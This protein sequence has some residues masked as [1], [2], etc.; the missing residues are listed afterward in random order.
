[1][2]TLSQLLQKYKVKKGEEYNFTKF[3][4]PYGCFFVPSD[5]IDSFF[6]SYVDHLAAGKPQPALTEKQGL[7]SPLLLDFDLKYS[8][9]TL[10]EKHYT[11][12]TVKNIV[13]AAFDCLQQYIQIDEVKC[14]VHE[15]PEPYKNSKNVIKDGFHLLFPQ[16][17]CEKPL[18]LKVRDHVITKCNQTLCDLNTTNDIQDIVDKAVIGVNNWFLFGSGKSEAKPYELTLILDHNIQFVSIDL[19]LLNKV[20]LFSVQGVNETLKWL[21]NARES[22]SVIDTKA[23]RTPENINAD[24]INQN[25][26]ESES[27]TASPIAPT[28][29]VSYETLEKVVMS[30]ADWRAEAEPDWIEIVWAIIKTSQDNNYRKSG[31]DLVHKF[32]KKSIS[33]YDENDVEIKLNRIQPRQNGK[34]FR[35]LVFFLKTDNSIVHD[36]LFGMKK[37]YI[38]VKTQIEKTHFKTLE[39]SGWYRQTEEGLISK[40]KRELI[41]DFENLYYHEIEKEKT[42]KRPFLKRWFADETIRTYRTLDFLP[43]PLDC[44][45][46]T[47]NLFTG[48]RAETLPVVS[49]DHQDDIALIWD[50]LSKLCGNDV[51]VFEYTLNWLAKIV[52]TPGNLSRTGLLW[53]SSEGTGKN[54]FLNWFGEKILGKRYYFTTTNITDLFGDFAIGLK[55]KLLV[56]M[57]EATTADTHSYVER[58][59]SAIT[60][61]TINYQAKHVNTIVLRNFARFVFSTNNPRAIKCGVT[62]RRWVAVECDSTRCNDKSYFQP[63]QNVLNDVSA[64]LIYD[65]LID[66]D[67]SEWDPAIRP[68]TALYKELKLASIP[69]LSKWLGFLIDTQES[70][71][72]EPASVLL[73][74]YRG[75]CSSNGFDRVYHSVNVTSFGSDLKKYKGVTF[76]RSNGTKYTFDLPELQN[77]LQSKKHYDSDSFPGDI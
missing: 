27:P 48:F 72:R 74:N 31:R 2:T 73:A 59:K 33:N 43:S 69:V 5:D 49:D 19:S 45:S 3:S 75:W 25:P 62:D 36:E 40:R 14:Y 10:L 46:D 21:P 76:I 8:C 57:N 39:P 16:V 35:S 65:F 66:R 63:L 55:H 44:P 37:D 17:R 26:I 54:V 70:V 50:L 12:E 7:C 56:N 38:S 71:V 22:L 13:S 67:I 4:K 42:A 53:Q 15:R 58:I 20:K 34:T 30:L 77:D 9:D 68:V 1:M 23:V 28:V 60:D 41:D 64:R 61:E 24:L 52:Q 6:S 51:F 29:E 32:S 11:L 47:Y 18:K